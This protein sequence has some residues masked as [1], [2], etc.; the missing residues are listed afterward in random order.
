MQEIEKSLIDANKILIDINGKIKKAF[1]E[2]GIQIE[3]RPKKGIT[4][5][6]LL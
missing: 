2:E 6:E 5:E 3:K 1:I 4:K